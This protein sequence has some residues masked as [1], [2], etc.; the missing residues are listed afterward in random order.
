[1]PDQRKGIAKELDR[2]VH[3]GEMIRM[4][5]VIRTRSADE[6]EEIIKGLKK[7]KG[8][9]SG[10]RKRKASTEKKEKV[11]AKDTELS[12]LKLVEGEDFGGP[13]QRWY[14]EAL[15]VVEQLLPDRY[16]EFRELYRLD[17]KPKELD[18]T[19]YTVS[20][21]IHGTTVS[22]AGRP[23]FNSAAVALGK[24]KDQID[25]LSS[26][27]VRLD[28]LLSDI[29]GSLEA[30]LLDDELATATEL[31]K[32]KHIR[33]AGVVAGV[34][35]ERHLKTVLANHAVSLGRKK[36][37]I[38]NLNDALKEAKV[39]DVPRWREVQRLGDIRNLCG[40][41]GEREPKSQEVQELIEGTERIIKTVF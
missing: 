5:E 4:S 22:R 31:L 18:V 17:K 24:A 30:T 20:E 29:E 16:V 12:L 38:G 23:L 32:A 10:S 34:V 15:R 14:S 26:A 8:P 28:S 3:D 27:R 35:L 13:Y 37:Q 39:F 25:I 6:R 9:K 2:L 21:Y 1:M 19:T 7:A 11:P 40:H 41:D 36:A 33:S